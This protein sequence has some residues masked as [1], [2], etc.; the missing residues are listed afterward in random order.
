MI[1]LPEEDDAT[2]NRGLNFVTIAPRR[3]LMLAGYE[4][5]QRVYEKAGIDCVTVDG[6]ELV[7][8][9]GAI[10]CL[11]GIVRRDPLA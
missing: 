9:A 8:A 2:L 1:W 7:K 3:I 10:G 11:T 4:A 5:V 6:S